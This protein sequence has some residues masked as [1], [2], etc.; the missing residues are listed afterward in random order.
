[1]NSV[2]TSAIFAPNPALIMDYVYTHTNS[3]SLPVAIPPLL[4]PSQKLSRNITTANST[5]VSSR[6]YMNNHNGNNDY[7]IP[8]YVIVTADA[9]GQLKILV[10]KF[11]I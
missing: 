2:V 8:P 4:N 10:N 6:T 11:R 9:K 5:K 7:T 1:H 3:P